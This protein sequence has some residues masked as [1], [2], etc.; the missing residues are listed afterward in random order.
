VQFPITAIREIKMLKELQHPNVVSLLDV[1]PASGVFLVQSLGDQLRLS[2][3]PLMLL[4]SAD[5]FSTVYMVFEYCDHDLAGLIDEESIAF[6]E[7]QVK[8]Y[9]KYLLEALD[10]CHRNGIV[11]RDIKGESLKLRQHLTQVFAQRAHAVAAPLLHS[12]ANILVSNNGDVKL[13]DFGLARFEQLSR[14]YTN[15]VITLWYRPPELLLGAV[16][17][18]DK[19]DIWSA[20][21]G[22]LRNFSDAV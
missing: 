1:V 16:A 18:T 14:L 5:D 8:H 13:A 21:Y 9:M 20:G 4:Y 10:H 7:A 6:S 15:R 3:R 2:Y 22:L 19:V 11:H 12:G 17:Y